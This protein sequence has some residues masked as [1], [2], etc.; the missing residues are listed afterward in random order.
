MIDAKSQNKGFGENREI[1]DTKSWNKDF[2]ENCEIGQI[3]MFTDIT[4]ICESCIILA[5]E[6]VALKNIAK[7]YES[8]NRKIMASKKFLK[9][10]HDS[11]NRL[12]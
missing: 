1:D 9:D 2:I 4:K 8:Q 7:P 11:Q 3:A 12:D 6:I 5:R 10:A